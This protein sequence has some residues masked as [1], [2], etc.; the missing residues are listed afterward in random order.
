MRQREKDKE[1]VEANEMLGAYIWGKR[2]SCEYG[3]V[4]IFEILGLSI[5]MVRIMKGFPCK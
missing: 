1:R 4:D 2:M 3:E 5:S